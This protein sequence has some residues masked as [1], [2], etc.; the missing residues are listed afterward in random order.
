M[1]GPL[2]R[3]KWDGTNKDG[4]SAKGLAIAES[5]R[6]NSSL[7]LMEGGMEQGTR[8]WLELQLEE[9]GDTQQELTL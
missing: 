1:K 2:Q 5:Q 6:P 4:W 3:W 7:G 9:L 8:A